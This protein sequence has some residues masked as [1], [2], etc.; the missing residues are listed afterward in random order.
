MRSELDK[1]RNELE[2]FDDFVTRAWIPVQAGSVAKCFPP[3]PDILCCLINE[4]PV[5][6]EVVEIC[7]WRI[8]SAPSRLADGGVEYIRTADPTWKIIAKKLKCKYRC[9]HPIELLC[10]TQ[11]RVVTPDRMIPA[12]LRQCASLMRKSAFRKVW[13]RSSKS[14]SLVWERGLTPR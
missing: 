12:K 1:S 14:V 6:F 5:A 9:E 11:G 2:V 3:K 7:D 8:A 13:F 10:Y 4:G